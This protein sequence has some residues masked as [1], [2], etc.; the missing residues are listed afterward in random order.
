MAVMVLTPNKKTDAFTQEL[1][2]MQTVSASNNLED[3][4]SDIDSTDL[5]NLDNE[6]SELD[7][8]LK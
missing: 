2:Q 8:L 4:Q 3:I 7:N 6:F 1:T 5:D